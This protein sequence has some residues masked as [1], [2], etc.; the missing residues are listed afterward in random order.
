MSKRMWQRAR[1]LMAWLCIG[2]TFALAES[3]PL[4]LKW[5]EV[6][7]I[8]ANHQVELTLTDGVKI[9]G[10]AIATREDRLVVDVKRSSDIKQYSAGTAAVPNSSITAAA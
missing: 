9:S 1:F 6:A 4:E 2:Q 10:E 5:E 3:K 8:V 7:L